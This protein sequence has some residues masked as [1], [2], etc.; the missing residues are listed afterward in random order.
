MADKIDE[1]AEQFARTLDAAKNNVNKIYANII[2]ADLTDTERV[3][4]VANLNLRR[5]LTESPQIQ[6]A[7]SDMAV[8][9]LGVLR[10]TDSFANVDD[11]YLQAL[12]RLDSELYVGKIGASATEIQ[13]L[14][15]NSVISKL[16]AS[17]F[18]K[19]LETTGL[20]THQANALANDSLRVYDRNVTIAQAQN[21]PADKLFHWDNP[22]DA[23][24]DPRCVEAVNAGDQP[25]SFWQANFSD[26]ISTGSHINCRGALLPA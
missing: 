10:G 12:I 25:M 23:R 24:T 18:A 21:A 26:I 3:V 17:E 22:I 11:A 8:A 2:N 1:A 13:T 7:L 4:A 6:K 15:S 20:Q 19:T 14:V 16:P 5:T 9:H